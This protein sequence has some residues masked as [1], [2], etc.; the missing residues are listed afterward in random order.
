MPRDVLPGLVA[1]LALACGACAGPP[2][3]TPEG[4]AEALPWLQPGRTS[5]AECVAR[6]GE[7]HAEF[8]AGP[9][10]TDGSRLAGWRVESLRSG[11]RPT[12]EPLRQNTYRKPWTEDSPFGLH[13]D[14]VSL[15]SL[16]VRFDDAGLVERAGAVAHE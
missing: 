10:R 11:V 12:A 7:P 1:L 13:A 9:D 6:L 14:E 16:V 5:R 4:F 8:A 2:L 3:G 15:W